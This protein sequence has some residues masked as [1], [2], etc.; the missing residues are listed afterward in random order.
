[1]KEQYDQK[2]S[3]MN[4]NEAKGRVQFDLRTM[5]AG[6]EPEKAVLEWQGLKRWS[7]D[8]GNRSHQCYLHVGKGEGLQL[9]YLVAHT[10]LTCAVR[11]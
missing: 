10:E 8:R 3:G 9:E 6:D 5:A 11:D 2:Y 1:M 4:V 7:L